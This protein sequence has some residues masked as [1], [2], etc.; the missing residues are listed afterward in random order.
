MVPG[1]K[2]ATFAARRLDRCTRADDFKRALCNVTTS[3]RFLMSCSYLWC[4]QFHAVTTCREVVIDDICRFA[5][6]LQT[7]LPYVGDYKT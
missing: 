3:P 5:A 4:E 2:T 6:R 1:C 7:D